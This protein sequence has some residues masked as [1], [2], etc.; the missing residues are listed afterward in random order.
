MQA[1]NARPQSRL[2]ADHAKSYKYRHSEK[3]IATRRAYAASE[4]GKARIREGWTRYRASEKGQALLG[5]QLAPARARMDQRLYGFAPGEREQL[6]LRQGML[7][8]I[9]RKPP[10]RRR[11]NVDHCH[12]CAAVDLRAMENPALLRAAADYFEH[13]QALITCRAEQAA[14]AAHIHAGS[15]TKG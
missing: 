11:L 8:A 12:E 14:N 13:E 3:G 1:P 2:E 10:K 6:E 9:C 7:C 15:L 4:A 5:R